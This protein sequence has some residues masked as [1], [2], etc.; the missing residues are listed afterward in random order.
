MTG[1]SFE[2]I[3]H[4]AEHHAAQKKW[5]RALSQRAGVGIIVADRPVLGCSLLMI[6]RAWHEGD[7]WSGQM[8]FPGG[9][10]DT[11]DAHITQTALREIHEELGIPE[12]QLRRFGRLSDVL[13]RP[14]RLNKTPMVISPLLFQVQ[15]EPVFHP[16]AEVDEV[17]WVP[18]DYFLDQ[19][20]RH[21]MEW[22]I[23]GI[24]SRLPCYEY[25]GKRIWGLSLLMIDEL[26][27]ELVQ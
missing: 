4:R 3:R 9:K 24:E 16:N 20:N 1:S 6:Q 15:Q 26:V 22:Q 2:A 13:A 25:R 12:K 11:D 10:H 27:Q 23:H 8:A 21:S 19:N 18:V 14:Y 7:P 17:I 5:Y